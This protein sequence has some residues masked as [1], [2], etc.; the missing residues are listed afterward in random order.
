MRRLP[1]R[2]FC[3]G[4]AI[5]L[6]VL[7]CAPAAKVRQPAKQKRSAKM[8]PLFMDFRSEKP[9][10]LPVTPRPIRALAAPLVLERAAPAGGG[11]ILRAAVNDERNSRVTASAGPLLDNPRSLIL[12]WQAPL[13]RGMAPRSVLAANARLLVSYDGGWQLLNPG[14]ATIQSGRLRASMAAIDPGSALFFAAD[15]MGV[16]QAR[17]LAD[18]GT[19]FGVIL[20]L[21]EDFL[22]SFIARHG[23]RLVVASSEIWRDPGTPQPNRSM[24]EVAD[25]SQAGPVTLDA[26]GGA[27]VLEM[28]LRPSNLLLAA[29]H[30]DTVALATEDHLCLLDLDL[31]IRQVFTG[32]FVPAAM[33]LD[34]AGRMYLVAQSGERTELWLVTSQGERSYAFALP[35][36]IASVDAPPIVGYDHTVYLLSGRQILAVGQHG[37]LLWQHASSAP[38]GGAVVTADGQLLVAEGDSVA[39][40]DAE[41]IRRVL[42]SIP[43]HPLVVPPLLTG[44]GELLVASRD[45]LYCVGR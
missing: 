1:I 40:F 22:R 3:S 26:S 8:E 34:E 36:G 9:I 11:A 6:L 42:Y 32:S 17:R 45:T 31:K 21:G 28:L 13:S 23:A 14:G 37:R 25:V 7:A 41:G 29:M 16:I 20:T 27:R 12:R 38:I 5:L 39:A 24:I 2:R 4:C 44:D 35:E 30:G 33:S 10:S 18:G 19:A 43:G 15:E